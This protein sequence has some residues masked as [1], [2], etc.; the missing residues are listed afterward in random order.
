MVAKVPSRV[1]RGHC[2]RSTEG[3]PHSLKNLVQAVHII[4][5]RTDRGVDCGYIVAKLFQ[6]A[7]HIPSDA[8]EGGN[9]SSYGQRIDHHVALYGIKRR[10]VLGDYD[11]AGVCF[12]ARLHAQQ[13]GRSLGSKYG[14][15]EGW[16]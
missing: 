7:A 9:P 2:V 14:M 13:S 4:G 16:N 11:I 5:Q 3:I 12:G 10:I 8:D 15:Y 1:Q 6:L